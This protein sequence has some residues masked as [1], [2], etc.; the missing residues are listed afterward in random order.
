MYAAAAATGGTYNICSCGE[1]CDIFSYVI[2]G[3]PLSIQCHTHCETTRKNIILH[4]L[5]ALP[6]SIFDFS[7]SA[8]ERPRCRLV[9]CVRF[10]ATYFRERDAIR[11]FRTV[12]AI[13]RVVFFRFSSRRVRVRRVSSRPS[14]HRPHRTHS[15][16]V[17]GRRG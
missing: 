7:P 17:R 6:P 1:I 10:H 2:N 3:R 16:A 13:R 15:V 4:F 9:H 5:F 11:V 14:R 12:R 8:Y